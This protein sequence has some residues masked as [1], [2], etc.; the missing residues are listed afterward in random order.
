MRT[1]EGVSVMESGDASPHSK[2]THL[3]RGKF[4]N[5]KQKTGG[6]SRTAR[7]LLITASG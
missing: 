6:P 5:G 1:R 7:F 2:A 4:A 3:R